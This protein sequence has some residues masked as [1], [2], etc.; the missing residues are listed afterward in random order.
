MAKKKDLYYVE[1]TDIIEP[2]Q[3]DKVIEVVNSYVKKGYQEMKDYFQQTDTLQVKKLSKEDAEGIVSKLEGIEVITKIYS[4]EDK[5]K[6]AQSNKIRCPRCGYVLEYPDWRCP[7]C[8]YEFPDYEYVDDDD[9][10][11]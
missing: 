8:Y 5:I 3:E 4:H 6:E 9:D 1:I 7:E 2:E 10:L 11:E